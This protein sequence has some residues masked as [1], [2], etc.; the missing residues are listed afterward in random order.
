LCISIIF[1]LSMLQIVKMFKII[2]KKFRDVTQHIFFQI[3]ILMKITYLS[4]FSVSSV[5]FLDFR[6]CKKY[7]RIFQLCS[8]CMFTL[9][10]LFPP[11]WWS[12]WLTGANFHIQ[13]SRDSLNRRIPIK[14]KIKN[15]VK[16]KDVCRPMHG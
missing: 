13:R 4:I 3:Y 16:L 9:C 14:R 1:F 12:A 2:K 8:R 15:S 5:R 10:C 11:W 6:I 7:I